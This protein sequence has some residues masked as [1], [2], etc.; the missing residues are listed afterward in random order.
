MQG[1]SFFRPIAGSQRRRKVLAQQGLL[2]RFPAQQNRE[3]WSPNRENMV[4]MQT[5][6]SATP[7]ESKLWR[8]SQADVV[9]ATSSESAPPRG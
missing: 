5:N 4:A 2:I 6:S 8:E 9:P 3:T 1:K 7:L